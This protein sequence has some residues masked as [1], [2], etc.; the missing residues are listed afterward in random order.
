MFEVWNS[1]VNRARKY[2]GMK[3]SIEVQADP[4]KY[5]PWIVNDK[6]ELEISLLNLTL[7]IELESTEQILSKNPACWSLESIS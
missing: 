2:S 6:L 3:V 1:R 4:Q 5:L 7:R